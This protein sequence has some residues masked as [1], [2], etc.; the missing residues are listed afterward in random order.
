MNWIRARVV[1]NNSTRT[2]KQVKLSASDPEASERERS[3]LFER[4]N[5]TVANG[6]IGAI[7]RRDR[8]DERVMPA[9]LLTEVASRRNVI[10]RRRFIVTI[11][12]C[13]S[14]CIL[15]RGIGRPTD[16]EAVSHLPAWWLSP[17]R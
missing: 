2:R 11:A 15:I 4:G 10:A 12:R 7:S 3:V 16:R 1:C 17:S 13:R 8:R 5:V 14:A 9:G 6:F